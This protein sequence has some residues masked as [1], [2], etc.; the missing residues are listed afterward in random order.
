[1]TL[2]LTIPK[3]MSADWTSPL[4]IHLLLG[5]SLEIPHLT[6]NP[7]SVE[8]CSSSMYPAIEPE[9]R[10]ASLI[11]YYSPHPAVN[12][13][14]QPRLLQISRMCCLCHTLVTSPSPSLPSNPSLRSIQNDFSIMISSLPC[15][16]S[17]QVSLGCSQVE[18]P[19]LSL[20]TKALADLVQSSASSLP[21]APLR[22]YAPAHLD[23]PLFL[24][25]LLTLVM[26]HFPSP[27]VLSSKVNTASR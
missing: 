20:S 7:R 16:T 5:I 26:P 1:M 17:S 10:A 6:L 18:V 19:A 13:S 27:L 3:H 25:H 21:L 4:G 14:C 12:K 2:W 9:T 23:L 8:T 15:Q 22:P 11:P 24:K